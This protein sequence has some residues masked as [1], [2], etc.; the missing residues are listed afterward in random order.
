MGH[1]YYL[2]VFTALS[3]LEFIENRLF[4]IKLYYYSLIQKTAY[5]CKMISTESKKEEMF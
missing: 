5:F 1:Y 4:W 2:L 3:S